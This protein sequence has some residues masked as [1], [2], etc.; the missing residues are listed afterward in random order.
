MQNDASYTIDANRKR[1]L[2][3]RRGKSKTK[4]Q[5][6]KSSENYKT[7]SRNG[8]RKIRERKMH[9]FEKLK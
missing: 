3:K 8:K 1:K 7:V 2:S 4:A 6:S 9:Q 5:S